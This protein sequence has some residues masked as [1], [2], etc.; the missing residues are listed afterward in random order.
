MEAA[1]QIAPPVVAVM[2]VC[3][4]GDWF[5]EVLEGLA[6]QDYANLKSLFLVVGDPGDVPDR[7]RERVQNAFVR[8]IGNT[9]GYG[10]AANEVLR[11]VEGTNGFFC[12][13]HD[14]VALDPGA[15]RLLVEELYRSN[16]GIVG[17]KLVSW[18]DPGVLQH[19]GIGVD[20]FGEVDS[21]VEEGE[22]DQEQHD[23][24]RD[25]FALPSACLMVRADLFKEIGGFDTWM[26]FYGDDVDL[27]WRAHLGGARVVVV[28]AARARHREALSERRPDL[29]P[30]QLQARHRMRSI[31]TLT[32]A[33]RLPLLAVQLVFVTLSELVVGVL[34][35]KPREAW[36][37]VRAMFGLIP[38]LPGILVRR[39]EVRA[40][41]HVPD[42]EIAGLQLHGSA[43]VSAYLRSRDMRPSRGEN[44]IERRW[45][46]TAGS[47]PMFAW[48]CVLVAML[49]G[50]RHLLSGIPRFGEFLQL[51]VS[52]RAMLSDYR[53]G[54]WG[55]GLGSTTPVPTGVALTAMGSTLTLFHMGLLHTVGVLGLLVIGYLGIWRLAT[56]FPTARARIAALVV[57][58]A[59]PLPSQLLSSGRWGALA[60]YAAA[61]WVVHLLRRSAG[62]ES[63]DISDSTRPDGYTAISARARL[64]MVSQLALLT[65]VT[66]AFVPSFA[67]VVVAIG[68][69]LAL[70]TLLGG[71]SW[72]PALILV[73]ISVAAA[74]L[75]FLANLPWASSLFG[76]H[77]WDLIAGVPAPVADGLPAGSAGS[78]ALGV[79]RL[80][81][82]GLGNG[83]FGILA[84]AL[85]LPVL[86]AP[87]VARSWRLTWAIR[88][89]G[90]VIVFGW[91]AVLDDRGL[92]IRLP[93]PGVLLAP[94]AVGLALSAAC[95]AAAFQDDV[96]AGS[97][98]WR[99][100][101]GLL[102]AAA[103]AIGVLPG[104]SAVGSGRWRM[105]TLTLTSVLGQF[106][107][108]PPEG[109]Y[110]ILWIGNPQVMPVASWTL[111]PG[112]GYAIT[113]DG[114]LTQYEAWP[115][116]PSETEAEVG[117]VIEQL[118]SESTLRGG[119]L[120]APYAIRYIVV[121]I[122]DGATSTVNA[123]L[124]LPN[125]L[126]DALDDQLDFAAPLTRPLNFLVY[127]NTAWL[128]TRAQF[129][130]T[131]ADATRQAGFD[132]LARL[133][134]S[135]A[136]TPVAV[137]A[138]DNTAVSFAA[139]AGAVTVATGVDH[140]W[141]MQV[142]SQSIA[143]RPAFGATT[144]YDIPSAGPATLRY[145]TSLSRAFALIGQLVLWLL[146]ALGV[147]RF[148]TTSI[149]RWRRRR[150]SAALEAPLL[151]IDAPIQAPTDPSVL[152]SLDDDS[153]PLQTDPESVPGSDDEG[154]E[155]HDDDRHEAEK[156]EADQ[157]AG[158]E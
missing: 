32:G 89:A 30:A 18:D 127:E 53:S 78:R 29:R 79:T 111:R 91:L 120:L 66:F 96:L 37:S 88:S 109:D 6:E 123:P 31:A 100:P 3:N 150:V 17:P 51:P 42:G 115:G 110:R 62:I 43:R 76:R 81:R 55:H 122:A 135:A 141:T 107:E 16:A 101:L 152:V 13:L 131:D 90:L 147:S 39:R 75:A 68:I 99:Q 105:P 143:P 59:V 54:W 86:V 12:F 95:I 7:V 103:V 125:G 46:Q 74:A 20:R 14:D 23:A 112:I 58:A 19:V 34:S 36:A 2:V 48:I 65:A 124:P 72:R 24:V 94:V 45:R 67:F 69:V 25:V 134:L 129:S 73:S 93:E 140:R 85:Y 44:S 40:L 61:P 153:I 22:V 144:G 35:G 158:V 157:Q 116:R 92:K 82:F 118:A 41:R 149:A 145:H 102:S 10:V 128:P 87:L 77:G 9:T 148:D 52:P 98:G 38:R 57:Y 151:S 133:D 132:S 136:A 15:I 49:F 5:D 104:L 142:G 71:G 50:S 108:N 126:V 1:N 70:T 83:Q 154:V 26:D 119:R 137:G 21:F 27:C 60:C 139:E 33:R 56:L 11:L 156:R 4:P 8:G 117:A 64:R 146:L 97:F 106:A 84:I 138:S 114:P 47:A 155:H 121:P 113:D 80:A 28:P 130:A 63:F